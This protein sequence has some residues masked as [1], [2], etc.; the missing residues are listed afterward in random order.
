MW[1]GVTYITLGW[2]YLIAGSYLSSAF[3]PSKAVEEEV[4][5]RYSSAKRLKQWGLL[6]V[7]ND[8]P[9]ESHIPARDLEEEKKKK[10]TLVL[11]KCVEQISKLTLNNPAP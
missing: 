10:R 7:K 2:K 6:T 5:C 4:S 1:I 8:Y 9:G 11:K 3:L